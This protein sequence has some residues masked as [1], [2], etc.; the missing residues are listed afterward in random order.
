M[1]EPKKPRSVGRPSK[2]QAAFAGQA[3]KLAA[4]GTTDREIAD[5]FEVDER[6]LYRWKNEHEEFCQALTLGKEGPDARVEQSLFQRAV[7]YSHDDVHISTY[8]G[9]VTLTPIVKHYPPDATAIIFWLKNRRPDRWR[10]KREE[11]PADAAAAAAAIRGL[12]KALDDETDGA[13]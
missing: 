1:S 7:G 10:E 5:F 13:A 6:T 4:L 9:K 8:E 12:L 2:Y 3:R 11:E